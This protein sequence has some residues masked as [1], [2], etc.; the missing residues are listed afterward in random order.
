MSK[1]LTIKWSHS[2]T[3]DIVYLILHSSLLHKSNFIFNA[4][5]EPRHDKT[6]KMSVRPSEDSDKPGLPPSPI[7][8]FTADAQADLSL[9]WAHTLFVGFVMSRLIYIDSEAHVY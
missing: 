6:N 3:S 4:L 8:V 2:D 5:Y 7:R 1:E 9:R